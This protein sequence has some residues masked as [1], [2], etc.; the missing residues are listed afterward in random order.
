MFRG[1]LIVTQ[2][3]IKRIIDIVSSAVVLSIFLPFFLVI[4]ILIKLGSKGPVFFRY[5]RAGKDG[6]LFV[7]Y[8]FRSMIEDAVSIGLGIETGKDDPRVTGIG[9][10]LRRWSLDEIP[11]LINVLKGEMSFVGPRPALPHQVEK[12]S[13]FE[14][15]RLEMKPG[16]T[17]WA[18]I[19]GRNLLSWK[20]RIKLDVWYVEN[21][22]LWLDFK[23]LL[24]TPKVILSGQGIY[25]KGGI[26]RDYE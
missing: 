12:Y 15:G 22:S 19:N 24:M 1:K 18:Q 10:F 23:I 20:D 16:I 8:K 4:A 9:A 3:F 2:L 21:W 17:G 11:Q 5:K 25:G 7:S 14:L 13:K 26:V 6:R